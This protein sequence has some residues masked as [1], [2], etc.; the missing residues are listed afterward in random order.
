MSRWLVAGALSL[1]PLTALAGT[2]VS[3]ASGCCPLG[4]LLGCC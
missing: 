4:A 1:V 3:A 2:A